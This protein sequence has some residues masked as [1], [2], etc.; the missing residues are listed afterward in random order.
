MNPSPPPPAPRRLRLPAAMS[1][2]T[3]AGIAAGIL[4]AGGGAA[5]LVSAHVSGAPEG[6]GQA[7][8]AATHATE[9]PEPSEQPEAAGSGDT[10]PSGHGAAVVSAVASCK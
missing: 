5:V 3:A 6:H 2:R 10:G 7:T 4:A 8:P 1:L 9:S